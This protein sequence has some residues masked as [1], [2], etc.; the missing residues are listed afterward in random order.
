MRSEGAEGGDGDSWDGWR[1]GPPSVGLERGRGGRE[2]REGGMCME[3]EGE[4]F[5]LR[6]RTRKDKLGP[7]ECFSRGWNPAQQVS[8]SRK[9]IGGINIGVEPS[10][11]MRA[12]DLCSIFNCELKS[13]L[14]FFLHIP[15]GIF[16]F[17]C[18]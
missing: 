13:V 12:D 2:T 16:P 10:L 4:A 5:V 9:Q 18:D 1:S 17:P 3:L 14:L 6:A 7:C 8:E 11:N 15:Q